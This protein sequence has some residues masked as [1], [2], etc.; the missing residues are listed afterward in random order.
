M[1][2]TVSNAQ[3]FKEILKH[4]GLVVVD[5]FATWCGPCKMIA[6]LIEKFSQQHPEAKFVKVDTDEVPD[7][8]QEYE[9]T[10]MPT[11][12]FLKGGKVVERVTGANPAGIKAAITAHI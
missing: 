10:A 5:F 12:L 6:P 3:E 7:L 8:S 11:I 4:D 1:V 9:I 2:A